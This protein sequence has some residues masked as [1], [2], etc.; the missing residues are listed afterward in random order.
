MKTN[1]KLKFLFQIRYKSYRVID[2][3]SIQIYQIYIIFYVC[4]D[5]LCH[6]L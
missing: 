2:F 5:E 3:G 4:I 6:K 1:V